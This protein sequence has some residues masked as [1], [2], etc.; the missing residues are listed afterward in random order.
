MM[1]IT[2]GVNDLTLQDIARLN[3]LL[4]AYRCAGGTYQGKNYYPLPDSWVDDAVFP[5]VHPEN[6][7]IMLTNINNQALVLG[8]GGALSYYHKGYNSTGGTAFDL[9]EEVL[10]L[11]EL[12]DLGGQS[13]L[14][15]IVQALMDNIKCLRGTGADINQLER[16]L[17]HTV[18]LFANERLLDVAQSIFIK[19]EDKGGWEKYLQG[20]KDDIANGR[21]DSAS[22]IIDSLLQD[23]D[24]TLSDEE[25]Y[26]SLVIEL[27]DV[28]VAQC[29]KNCGYNRWL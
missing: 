25:I 5:T 7:L 18:K 23:F 21:F 15:E 8:T 22:C 27:V 3:D 26:Q 4:I 20:I 12:G 14:E 16:A 11:D 1:V 19:Q 9:A 10:A 24:V 6:G 2:I 28:V 29:K 13:D 17:K